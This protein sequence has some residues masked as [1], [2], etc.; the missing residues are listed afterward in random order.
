M[1]AAKKRKIE[2]PP[3]DCFDENIQSTRTI[4]V[5][6]GRVFPIQLNNAETFRFTIPSDHNLWINFARYTT[7]RAAVTHTPKRVFQVEVE[8]D[9]EGC[10]H[11]WYTYC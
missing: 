5:R 8:H 6:S 11:Q 2:K 7:C 4:E 3:P 10:E 9:R 1:P